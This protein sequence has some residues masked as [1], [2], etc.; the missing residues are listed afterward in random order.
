MIIYD[1]FKA[2]N[3]I[4][5]KYNLVQRERTTLFGAKI[6]TWTFPD[7]LGARG[8]VIE[9]KLGLRFAGKCFYD[10]DDDTIKFIGI[11]P[12]EPSE[13]DNKIKSLREMFVKAQLK[14]KEHRMKNKIEKIEG[15]FE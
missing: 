6:D 9:Y 5:E 15:D 10:T 4:K 12:V 7:A 8:F 14:M 3:E 1:S 13:Y 2:F 11:V